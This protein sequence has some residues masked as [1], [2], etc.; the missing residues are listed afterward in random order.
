MRDVLEQAKLASDLV[1]VLTA[2]MDQPS[3]VL[4]I[5][6]LCDGVI[7]LAQRS[8]KTDQAEEIV[9]LLSTTGTPLL[10]TVL[11]PAASLEQGPTGTEQR[12]T[13]AEQGFA[14]LAPRASGRAPTGMGGI[15]MRVPPSRRE[16]NRRRDQCL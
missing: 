1:L 7:V 13:G 3:G 5:A 6:R 8:M 14:G 9:D 12:P 11:V 15:R 2:P 10:G 4:P 16:S